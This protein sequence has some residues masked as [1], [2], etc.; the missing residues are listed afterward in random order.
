MGNIKRLT[1]YI[2]GYAHGKPGRTISQ[3]RESKELCRGEFECTGIVDKLA[4]YEDSEEQGLLAI[5]AIA[6]LDRQRDK[7][8]C[9]IK[10]EKLFL[11]M[12]AGARAIEQNK[13]LF[14]KTYVY[15]IFGDPKEIS[16]Y[17]A[18]KILRENAYKELEEI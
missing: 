3:A 16:F 7:D 18:S 6:P 15:D 17:E 4:E 12:C 9:E 8:P 11:A 13:R 1:E 14:G 2:N 10:D 5:D